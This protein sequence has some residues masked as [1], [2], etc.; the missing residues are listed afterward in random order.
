MALARIFAAT[1]APR[2]R[3]RATI[4]TLAPDWASP[5]AGV[6]DGT[7]TTASRAIIVSSASRTPVRWSPADSTAVT[8]PWA[9]AIPTASSCRSSDTPKVV[10]LNEIEFQTSPHADDLDRCPQPGPNLSLQ[11][12]KSG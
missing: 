12:R 8:S 11:L 6:A 10:C 5:R 2:A 1:S 3:S 7:T 9:T 4:S